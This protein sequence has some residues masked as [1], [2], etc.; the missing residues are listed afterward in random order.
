MHRERSRS[1]EW[2]DMAQKS[3]HGRTSL[4]SIGEHEE[5]AIKHY[6]GTERQG[7]AGNEEAS[8]RAKR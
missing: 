8:A 1:D 7:R 5:G 4:Y 3:N 2:L 6:A